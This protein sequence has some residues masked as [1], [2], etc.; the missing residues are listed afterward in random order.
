MAAVAAMDTS[1]CG[2]AQSR[3]CTVPPPPP[4][5]IRSELRTQRRDAHGGTVADADM[6]PVSRAVHKWDPPRLPPPPPCSGS[7]FARPAA[8]PEA[9]LMERSCWYREISR[10]QRRL[11]NGQPLVTRVTAE[12]APFVP[13][14]RS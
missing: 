4:L 5:L 6:G 7:E 1:L 12:P 13:A 11:R 14:E 10:Q 3:G 8:A 9:A 2:C